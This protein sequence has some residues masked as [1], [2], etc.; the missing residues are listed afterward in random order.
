MHHRSPNRESA[1]HGRG[2]A[3]MLGLAVVAVLAISVPTLA[4]DAAQV[5]AGRQLWVYGGCSSCHGASGEGGEGGR[6]EILIRSKSSC[7]MMSRS[8]L[9]VFMPA[10][11]P[12]SRDGKNIQFGTCGST[13][14]ETVVGSCCRTVQCV[15]RRALLQ[16]QMA[17][18]SDSRLTFAWSGRGRFRQEAVQG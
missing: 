9:A 1:S 8:Q 11:I 18:C 6:G 3:G 17:P 15:S 10:R 5:E 14:N 16:H 4:Q 12:P 13:L 2:R 7:T